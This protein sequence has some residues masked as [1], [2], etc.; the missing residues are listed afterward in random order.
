MLVLLPP[1]ETKA[2]GGDGGPL[3]LS[4]LSHP[5]LNPTRGKLIEALTSLAGDVPASLAALG[6]SE[7]QVDEVRRNA[8]LR[9]APT[10]PALERYTGVLYDALDVGSLSPAERKQADTRL[11]VA[12]ALFGLALGTDSIPAYRLSGGSTLP[13]L[14]TLRALWRPVLEPLFADSS[15]LVVDLRSGAYAALARIPHAVAVRVLSEDASGK[16]KVVSHH[17]KAHK[18]RLARALARTS[19]EPESVEDVVEVAEAAGMRV[20]REGAR[21]ICV[22]VAG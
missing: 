6:L 21:G 15:Q 18:G 7:R 20:E 5:E 14:G 3:D 8:E 11:A 10:A 12:S 4:A 17:N 13:G 16:R 1:S 22:V 9:D 19:A 2:V